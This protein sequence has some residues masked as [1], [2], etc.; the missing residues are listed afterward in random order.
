MRYLIIDTE[1]NKLPDYKRSAQAEGQPRLAE[2]AAIIVNEHGERIEPEYQNYI[3]PDGWTM[4]A[5]ATSVNKITQEML[6]RS[7]VPVA[8]VLQWYMN[9]II[10]DQLPV[11]AYG[12]QFDTK[13]MRGELRRREGVNAAIEHR[14]ENEDADLFEVTPN[15]CLMRQARPFAK[16]IGRELVKASGSNK[17][18]P[19]LTD[20]CDFLGVIYDKESL[21]GALADARAAQ[22]CFAV[23]VHQG[24]VPEP[25]V[26][27]SKDY[28]AIKAAK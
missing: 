9:R 18:W 1:T 5:E 16:L 21:H 28:E 8:E 7:G 23:M 15:V 10:I 6:E 17:G 27:Y 24:F 22:T 12:A 25:M 3:K 26:H 14:E 19:K 2:F 20:L 13:I 11:I 4:E